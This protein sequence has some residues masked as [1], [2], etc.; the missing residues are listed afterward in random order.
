VLAQVPAPEHGEGRIKL[1]VVVTDKAGK[2]VSGLDAKDFTL[3]D[4]NQP[5]KILSFQAIDGIVQKAHPPVEVILVIDTIN[6]PMQS[7]AFTRQQIEK[8]LRQNGGHLAQPVSLFVL[9][10]KG[11]NAQQP[12]STD[13]NAL[14]ADLD[15]VSI[16]LRTIGGSAGDNGAGELFKL[17]IDSLNFIV[18][19][20][21]TKPGRKLLIWSNSGWPLLNN[22]R[23]MSSPEARQQYFK[24][25]VQLSNRLREARISVYSISSGE[26]YS[27]AREYEG[28]L[29]GVKSPDK[30]GIPNLALRVLAIQSGGRILGPSNDMAGQMNSCIEDAGAF[31]SLSFDPPP[32]AQQNEYHDLKVQIG[33]PGLTARTSSGYYNQP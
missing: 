8:F 31:Y 23:N 13:G 26:T 18:R 2:P 27:D 3:L 29:K 14:A 25:I 20:E 15:H 33:K 32:A 22:Q 30:A 12:T 1:D 7:V 4:N 16:P 28:F 10:N 24:L 21:M 6:F 5:G 11:L 19:N 9:T 17:S